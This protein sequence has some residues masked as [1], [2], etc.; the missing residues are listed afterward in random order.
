MCKLDE[1][2]HMVQKRPM[3]VCVIKRKKGRI[4]SNETI[5]YYLAGCLFRFEVELFMA[6]RQSL[7]K[8]QFVVFTV[9]FSLKPTNSK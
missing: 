6:G 8:V 2:T 3:C 4:G 9:F 5:I 1:F 7:P